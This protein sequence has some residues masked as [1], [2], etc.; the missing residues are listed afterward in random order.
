M[1]LSS[2]GFKVGQIVVLKITSIKNT[3]TMK[4]PKNHDE[5]HQRQA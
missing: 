4:F 5:P 3:K 1:F 2:V